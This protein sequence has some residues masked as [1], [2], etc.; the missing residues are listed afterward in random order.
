MIG[1]VVTIP[2]GMTFTDIQ[3][4]SDIGTLTDNGDGTFTA[5]YIHSADI[6]NILSES[7]YSI[8]ALN[9][10]PNVN[11][12]SLFKPDRNKVSGDQVVYS[13]TVPYDFGAWGFIAYDHSAPADHIRDYTTSDE[14]DETV[15]GGVIQAT[16]RVHQI[17]WLA[18]LGADNVNA[19]TM[20]VKDG[21][22]DTVGEDTVMLTGQAG[23]KEYNFYL[24]DIPYGTYTCELW[25]TEYNSGTDQLYYRA[26]VPDPN[27]TWSCSISELHMASFSIVLDSS[28][29]DLDGCTLINTD[30]S[31]IDQGA[32]TYDIQFGVDGLTS[33]ISD[34]KLY[35]RKNQG[36]WYELYT[37]QYWK[38]D[39]SIN[40]YSG[41]LPFS[42]TYG[43]SVEFLVTTVSQT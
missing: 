14:Y 11:R 13:P 32:N 24:A 43:D 3:N 28:D 42:I 26:F 40:Y 18:E 36:T 25:F 41:D 38:V 34:G 6:R 39:G 16:Y 20:R 37:G 22:G 31:S 21:N 1:I 8:G 27:S 19:L 35:V 2:S 5:K 30:P 17:D 29:T 7:T 9:A 12:F 23:W 10:S 33:S 15:S 4:N